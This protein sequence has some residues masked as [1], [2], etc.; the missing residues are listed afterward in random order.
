MGTTSETLKTE[1]QFTIWSFT[2][3]ASGPNPFGTNA[4]L[5][6][7]AAAAISSFSGQGW[8][9]L[10][11]TGSTGQEFLVYTPEPSILILLVVGLLALAIGSHKRLGT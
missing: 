7:A 6:A 9:I 2:S 1:Y 10:T 8:E 5:V 4:K 11:P 3:G